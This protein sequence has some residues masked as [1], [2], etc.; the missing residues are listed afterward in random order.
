MK[1]PQLFGTNGIRGDAEKLFTNEFCFDIGATFG[2][3]LL[4][5]TRVGKIAVGMDPRESSERIKSSLLQ[6]LL[7][8]ASW[9]ILDEGIIP[10]PG[11]N[12]FIKKKRLPAGIIISGS[13]IDKELNG[14]KFFVD[15]EEITKKDEKE[16]EKIYSQIR[17]K[18]R[19]QLKKINVAKDNEAREIYLDL[20]IGLAKTPFPSW[21]I[22]VDTSNGTQSLIIPWVL[23]RLGFD[24]MKINCNLNQ[25]LIVRDME[26][27]DAFKE[28]ALTVKKEKADFGVA[29]DP[30]GDRIVFFDEQG[31]SIPGEYSCSLIALET[32][33]DIIV[34]PV[35]TSSVVEHLGKK[36]VRTKVGVLYV[37]EAMKKYQARFGFESNGGGI[38]AEIFYGRDGG[39][40]LIKMLNLLK[41][42]KRT[43]SQLVN[44]LPQF[45]IFKEKVDC[46]RKLNRII[47]KKAEE[48]FRGIKTEK[49]DGLKIWISSESWILFR[50][51]GNASEFRVFAEAK[52]EKTAR[53]L[54]EEGLELVKEVIKKNEVR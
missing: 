7:T 38:S 18:Q 54:G 20:L 47:L 4:K 29:L 53:K 25:G 9:E 43:L 44:S 13:H 6:G 46:P 17:G 23:E 11:L 36:V 24:V 49:I 48:V 21:K 37:V 12:Y 22:V 51:S 42:E 3:F 34:T 52:D 2:K 5:R 35:N 40:T 8:T 14:I 41:K 26:V 50:P 33:S 15:D 31:K 45:F 30:D 19:F 28:V 16:I 27:S 10:T 32:P 39:T 1:S